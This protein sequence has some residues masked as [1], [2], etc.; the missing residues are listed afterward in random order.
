MKAF[1]E[2]KVAEEKSDFP[3]E[4]ESSSSSEEEGEE[5]DEEDEGNTIVVPGFLSDYSDE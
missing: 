3:S 4:D 5:D 2:V 1:V